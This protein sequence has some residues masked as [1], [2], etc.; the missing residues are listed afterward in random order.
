MRAGETPRLTA[1]RAPAVEKVAVEIELQE[2]VR[3]RVAGPDEAFVVDEVIRHER[4]LARGPVR[5]AQRPQVEEV[6]VGVEHLHALVAAIDDEQ[7]LVRADRDAVHGV[8]LVRAG[9]RGIFRRPAPVLDEVVVRVVF[10]DA[11]AAVAV[12]DEVGAVR[13]PRDVSR[14]IERVR[15]AAAHAQLALAHLELPVVREAIDHVQLVV[16]D[17]DVLLG[18][19]RADLDLMRAAAARQLAEQLLEVRPLVDEVAFAVDDDDR[20]F[21]APFPAA[22]RLVGTGRA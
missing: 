9:I 21:P 10:R 3:E 14:P 1:R 16:D 7:A 17:P 20:V 15:A 19:V 22:L 4:A 8:E 11:R 12:R 18:V 13:Q 2:A 6:A 5:R